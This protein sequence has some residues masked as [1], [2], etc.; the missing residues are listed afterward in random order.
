[1]SGAI[2]DYVNKESHVEMLNGP[3]HALQTLFSTKGH[4]LCIDL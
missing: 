4:A 1:M 3:E 2:R